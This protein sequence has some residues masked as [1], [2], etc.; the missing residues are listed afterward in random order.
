MTAAIIAQV[1]APGEPSPPR[2]APGRAAEVAAWAASGAMWLTGP[3][4]GPPL[5]PPAGLVPK[6]RSIGGLAVERAAALGGRLGPRLG[7]PLALLGQRAALA[8]L[9]R[10]GTVSCGG[11][12]RLLAAADGWLAVS[13][14]RSADVELVPAWLEIDPAGADRDQPGPADGGPAGERVW[15]AVT[16]GVADLPAGDAVARARLLGLPAAVLPAEPPA[17]AHAPPPL[18][19]LP[20]RATAAEGPDAAPPS[21]LAGIMVADL[22]SLWAGPLAGALLAA[23]GARVVKVESTGRPDGARAGPAAFFDLLNAGKRS[24]ALDLGTAAGSHLLGELLARADVVLEASRPRALAQLGIDAESLLAAARPRVWVSITGHGRAHPQRDWTAFGDDA[25]VSGGLV[26]WHEGDPCFCADA[27]AD[28]A[29]GLVAAAA[30]LDALAAGGRWLLDVAM[31]GVAAHL[32]GPTLPAGDPPPA[33][34]PPP[35]PVPAPGRAAELGRHTA[36]VL[37]ELGLTP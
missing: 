32:A 22:G 5:G 26:S 27:V 1:N 21:T 35:V 8:G 13:L 18:A 9:S 33:A 25:A 17:A 3:P 37:A 30:A 4:D 28:P 6:L 29:S 16:A 12:T 34:P 19:P 36:E 20:L 15:E 23:A 11:A 31:A 14:A 10:R 24:V 7:D 2:P